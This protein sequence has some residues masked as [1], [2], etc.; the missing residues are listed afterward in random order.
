MAHSFGDIIAGHYVSSLLE[1]SKFG[2]LSKE[3]KQEKRMIFSLKAIMCTNY[4][5]K[6][7]FCEV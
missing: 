1:L 7:T 2:T 3:V 6:S 5:E 4:L